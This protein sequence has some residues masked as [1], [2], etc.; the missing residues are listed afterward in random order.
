[1]S[2][3][4]RNVSKDFG[5]FRSRGTPSN[6]FELQYANYIIT[7]DPRFVE[8]YRNVMV[9]GCFGEF[10]EWYEY[11]TKHILRKDV[12]EALGISF[13]ASTSDWVTEFK[14]SELIGWAF[15]L[16]DI[17]VFLRNIDKVE[18]LGEIMT[19][20]FNERKPLSII[21]DDYFESDHAQLVLDSITKVLIN[22]DHSELIHQI[23][24]DKI[25][26]MVE[27]YGWSNEFNPILLEWIYENKSRIS[28]WV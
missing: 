10:L 22:N 26:C 1:M 7:R 28:K 3:A 11:L 6:L 8:T 9:H 5:N 21:D 2:I 4:I 24:S 20:F 17:G 16:N 12:Q 15:Q 23:E 14:K 27:V 13:S 19:K 25:L 18:R